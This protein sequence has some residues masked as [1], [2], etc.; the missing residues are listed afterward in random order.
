[1]ADNVTLDNGDLS[2]FTVLTDEVAGKHAQIVKLSVSADGAGDPIV[3]SFPV[4]SYAYA[5]QLDEGATYT[6]VGEA[7]PGTLTSAGSWRIKRLTNA[8]GALLWADGNASFDN[9]WD[10]RASL[11]YS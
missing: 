2:N 4:S 9:V 5:M 8:S 11:S 6:Y 7:V 1:M 10:N 3:G